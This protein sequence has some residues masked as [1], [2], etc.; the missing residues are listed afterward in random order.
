MAV[1]RQS[2]LFFFILIF[3]N[4]FKS[5]A[6]DS[7][8]IKKAYKNIIRFNLTNPI[9]FGERSLMIGY[10]RIVRNNQSFSINAGRASFPSPVRKLVDS[11]IATK[12]ELSKSFKDFGYTFAFD[13]RFYLQKENKYKAP[14]GVYVGP[15]YNFTH[16]ERQNT[17]ELSSSN[18]VGTVST[19]FKMNVQMVGAQMGYQFIIW[20]RL[21]IDFVLLGPGIAFYNLKA[22][23]G[24]SLN[25]SDQ[26]E[27]L[28]LIQESI[29]NRYPGY[30][31]ILDKT[32][33]EKTG[34]ARTASLGFRYVIH[35]GFYF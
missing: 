15:Y 26:A 20:K 31:P 9:I 17:W 4:A 27:L 14:R 30:T 29:S 21:A 12:V 8:P 33:F 32:E 24:T 10:E 25:E 5:H 22:N 1:S 19:Q 11:T 6:Q 3:F 18:F 16:F 23:I 28:K 2:V 35:L 7:I 13:Y 34:N